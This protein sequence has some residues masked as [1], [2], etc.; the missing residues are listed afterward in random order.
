MENNP[1]NLTTV[2][3]LRIHNAQPSSVTFCLEP[4]ADEVV[5][6]P[7]GIYEILAKGPDGDYLEVLLSDHRI[8]VYGW[9]G[10]VASVFNGGQVVL[11]CQIPV[12]PVPSRRAGGSEPTP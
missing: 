6:P 2:Q 12:P 5:M 11:D 3:R 7:D 9:S 4:W 10:S 8:T 1:T